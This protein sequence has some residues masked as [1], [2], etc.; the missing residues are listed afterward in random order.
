MGFDFYSLRQLEEEETGEAVPVVDL[1]C[2]TPVL[3][4]PLMLIFIAL[5]MCRN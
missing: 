1:S 3:R 2:E 5:F 4:V